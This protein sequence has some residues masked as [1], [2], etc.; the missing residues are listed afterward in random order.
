M[1]EPVFV[2]ETKGILPLLSEMQTHR[3]QAA[4]VVD[5]YGGTAG[6]VTV[7]DIVEE[8]VGEIADEFDR[9]RRYITADGPR[10]S[11]SSTAVCPI[12]DAIGTRAAR[13]G[14][15]RVRDGRRVGSGRDRTHSAAGRALRARRGTGSGSRR[16]VAD[17]SHGC[18]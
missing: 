16:C 12:E 17:A 18:R 13:D 4:I 5:E 7:E 15:G 14:V 6:L 1:R 2:P 11:G 3:N 9:D 8:V 10:T